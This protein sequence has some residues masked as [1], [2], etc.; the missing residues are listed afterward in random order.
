MLQFHPIFHNQKQ[1]HEEK[2]ETL[3][4]YDIKETSMKT[5][6]SVKNKYTFPILENF[7][8]K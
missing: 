7:E 6:V 5:S 2:I 8:N 4:I 1:Y 3:Q